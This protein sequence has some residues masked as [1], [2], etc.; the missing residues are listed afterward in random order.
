[1][2]LKIA[3][4]L[5]FL[6]LVTVEA[7]AAGPAPVSIEAFVGAVAK[8]T[9][10]PVEM[11]RE[12]AIEALRESGTYSNEDLERISRHAENGFD[13]A[14]ANTMVRLLQQSAR[15]RIVTG[16]EALRIDTIQSNAALAFDKLAEHDTTIEVKKAV[17]LLKLASL[18]T[19]VTRT[20][21][22]AL[23][24]K[25]ARGEKAEDASTQ[26]KRAYSELSKLKNEVYFATA[27]VL[28]L[29]NIPYLAVIYRGEPMF[30][31]IW[32]NASPEFQREVEME[33]HHTLTPDEIVRRPTIMIDTAE[34]T[35]QTSYDRARSVLFLGEDFLHRI[36]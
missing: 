29:A 10:R 15:F 7:F 1:M 26:L 9:N 36:K 22:D 4:G 18:K 21:I 34:L 11:V 31:I 33:I 19:Q 8:R 20:L 3:M 24:A 5:L 25:I 17:T 13:P 14:K 23:D 12:K 28:D 30:E 6:V 16:L 2:F 35:G 27:K 32:S